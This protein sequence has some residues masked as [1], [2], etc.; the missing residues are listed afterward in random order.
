MSVVN[1]MPY[2]TPYPDKVVEEKEHA[3]NWNYLALSC[4][5][6]DLIIAG[7]GANVE[8]F[9]DT[10]ETIKALDRKYDLFCLGVTKA[11]H[12]RHPLYLKKDA[13][14]HPWSVK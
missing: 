12:P 5:I 9:P 7:W 6:A 3:L 2:V 4:Q 13:E 1:V 8:K 14:L 11:G 10:L